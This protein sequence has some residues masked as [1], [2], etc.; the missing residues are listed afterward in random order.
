MLEHTPEEL[1]AEAQRL[2]AEAF[3]GDE[4]SPGGRTL[5]ARA[6]A[7][8]VEALGDRVYPVV[9]CAACYRVT[10]WTSAA[11][12]CDSCVRSAEL[13]EAYTD[14]RGGWVEVTDIRSASTQWPGLPLRNRLLGLVA[15]GATVD[16][17]WL[18]RVEPD[19][20]GPA[21]PE[22]GFE[23]EGANREEIGAAD[24]SGFVIRFSSRTYRFDHAGW[25]PLETTRIARSG[26]LVPA[27]FS[28]GLPIE[29]L[30][31]AWG[32]F[33]AAVDSFNGRAWANESVSRDTD[34][35]A[36]QEREDT[37][38]NQEHVADMLD[39]G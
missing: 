27:E 7:L 11:G 36:R 29:Q 39:D 22:R 24:G 15:R 28:A 8:R 6:A 34:R 14:P 1:L 4:E 25:V 26:M 9:I 17:A 16:R 23:L 12:V 13:N 20:T 21:S 33:R 31:E 5:R 2:E 10:G 35:A 3:R 38:R 18:S 30:A 37:L 32:D 19:D